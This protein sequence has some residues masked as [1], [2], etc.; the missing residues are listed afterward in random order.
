M[1]KTEKPKTSKKLPYYYEKEVIS[2][3]LD[4]ANNDKNIHK[5]RNYLILLTLWRTGMRASEVINLRKE[6]IKEKTIIIRQG[7]GNIDRTIP[8][9]KE[10][11]I[12]FGFYME[13]KKLKPKDKL[14]NL[15]VR[16][17]RNIV[18]KYAPDDL[19][20]HPHTFRHSFA[21]YC[22]K[23]G[24]NLRSLQKILGHSSLT[25]TEIYLKMTGKDVIDDFEKV[26]W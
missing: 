12:L 26:V 21:M 18:Y 3:I 6:D 14:F 7:K 19:D 23:S 8:L 11:G 24:M 10:L 4:K 25:T 15:K 20:I 1:E 13:T 5:N 17:L 22:L 2:S 9:D 16:Q